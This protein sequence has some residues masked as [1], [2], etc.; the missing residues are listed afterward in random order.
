MIYY[1]DREK[2]ESCSTCG[3]S[4][5]QTKNGRIPWKVLRHFPMISRL[6]AYYN[7]GKKSPFFNGYKKPK[8]A[9][10]QMW[11]YPNDCEAWKHIHNI[12]DPSFDGLHLGATIDGVN[13]YKS[14]SA[15]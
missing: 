10:Q 11:T 9:N 2:L 5:Y 14:L 6:Q 7:S 13:P 8:G 15:K 3:T 1:K 4:R 12:I